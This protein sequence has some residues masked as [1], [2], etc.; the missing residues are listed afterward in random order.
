MERISRN[1]CTH[2]PLLYDTQ[3]RN[4]ISIFSSISKK[5]FPNSLF[6][7]NLYHN[8]HL[9]NLFKNLLF[10]GFRIQKKRIPE[11]VWKMSKLG[12][13]ENLLFKAINAYDFQEISQPHPNGCSCP[14]ST[15]W[16]VVSA[17]I[18]AIIACDFCSHDVLLD[19]D[20][21]FIIL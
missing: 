8:P 4:K 18:C 19:A 17:F 9:W 12:P 5:I 3:N 21:L 20:I 16:N 10:F 13:N 14:K 2:G 15:I 1:C 11:N 6:W 7:P